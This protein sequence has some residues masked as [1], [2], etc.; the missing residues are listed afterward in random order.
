MIQGWL[1]S[2]ISLINKHICKNKRKKS[3]LTKLPPTMPKVDCCDSIESYICCLPAF[4]GSRQPRV[5]LSDV[6]VKHR[7]NHP[8]GTGCH[9]QGDPEQERLL[10]MLS[11]MFFS[12]DL[13][14][15]RNTIHKGHSVLYVS[16]IWRCYNIHYIAKSGIEMIESSNIKD[17]LTCTFQAAWIQ[18]VL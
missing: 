17:W 7:V 13:W 14:Y 11:I 5:A 8:E 1:Y 4:Q 15:S 2:S 18:S 12:H 6:E 9:Y 10:Y 16:D 3:C